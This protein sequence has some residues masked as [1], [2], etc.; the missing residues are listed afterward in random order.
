[1]RRATVVQKSRVVCRD[2]VAYQS[3]PMYSSR[4]VGLEQRVRV[5]QSGST[6]WMK[7]LMVREEIYNTEE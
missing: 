3:R 5:E 4:V 7:G 2:I 6:V 1:V